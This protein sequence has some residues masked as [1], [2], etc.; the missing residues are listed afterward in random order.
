MEIS[1]FVLEQNVLSLKQSLE[2]GAEVMLFSKVICGSISIL[3]H[4]LLQHSGLPSMSSVILTRNQANSNENYIDSFQL[5]FT[6]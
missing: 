1:L 3:L 6:A 2:N 4:V 5:E